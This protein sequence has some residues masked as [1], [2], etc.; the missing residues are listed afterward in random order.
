MFMKL[1]EEFTVAIRSSFLFV[2]GKAITVHEP[3]FGS[4][5]NLKKRNKRD[6]FQVHVDYSEK[7][8]I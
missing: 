2:G 8:G 5:Q 7:Y 1:R 6:E 4:I 3:K